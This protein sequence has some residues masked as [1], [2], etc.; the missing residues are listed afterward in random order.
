MFGA[1]VSLPSFRL[2]F[3]DPSPNLEGIFAA[4]YDIGCFIGC[5]VAFIGAE[6]FGRK[7][8]LMWGTWIMVLGTIL[9]AAAYE[10]VQMILSRVVSGIGNGINTCAVRRSSNTVPSKRLTTAAGTDVAS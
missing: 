2:Q 10:N 5:I 4:I 3:N 6:R 8:S 7:G 9:Q 1:V